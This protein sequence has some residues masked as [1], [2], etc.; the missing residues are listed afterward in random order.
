M[1]QIVTRSTGAALATRKTVGAVRE[2]EGT[3][4]PLDHIALSGLIIGAF[5]NIGL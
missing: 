4:A 1:I 3:E 2:P 5:V